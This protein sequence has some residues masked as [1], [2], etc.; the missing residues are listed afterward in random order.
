L[1]HGCLRAETGGC[2]L[3]CESDAKNSVKEI[4]DEVGDEIEDVTKAIKDKKEP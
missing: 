4:V 3:T 1:I 2:E